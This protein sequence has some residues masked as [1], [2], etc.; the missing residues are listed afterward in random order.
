LPALQATGTVKSQ[1]TFMG[2]LKSK[3]EILDYLWEWAE[4]TGHWAKLESILFLVE[5]LEVAP[6]LTPPA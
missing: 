4:R 2:T 1:V 6:R 3:K 5:N